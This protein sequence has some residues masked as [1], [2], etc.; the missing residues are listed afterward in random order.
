VQLHRDVAFFYAGS[1]LATSDRATVSKLARVARG[2]LVS[3]SSAARALGESRAVAARKLAT[4]ARRGWIQ[5]AKRG[6]YLVRP[7][8]VSPSEDTVAE[9]PWVVADEVFDPC[10]IGG[11]SAAEYWNLTEQ[12]FRATL[13]V[14]AANVRSQYETLLGHT[15]RLF[16]V[17]ASRVAGPSLALVW[18]G[19]TRVRI[20]TPERTVADCLRNPELCGGIRHVADVMR[21][22]G[23]TDRRDFGKVAEAM[24]AVATGAAWKRLGYLAETI[25]PE[26][27][28]LV[29]LSARKISKGNARLDPAVERSGRLLTK[30]RLWVNV[31]L[32]PSQVSMPQ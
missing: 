18:R 6:V 28:A 9:D 4:L 14:T 22:Y 5:R 30:W 1:I 11:W 20:S 24:N 27:K 15:F 3:I 2:G 19:T 21:E 31:D 16:R 32:T 25:W 17:P 26:A 13:V 7:L 8:E 10:Y 23:S 12:I 29:A